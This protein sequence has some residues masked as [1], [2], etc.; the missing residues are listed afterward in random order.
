MKTIKTLLMVTSVLSAVS[1][2]AYAKQ[3]QKETLTLDAESIESLSVEAGA[4]E[5]IIRGDKSTTEISVVATVVGDEV[6]PGDYILSL[7]ASGTIAKLVAKVLKNS[8]NYKNAAYIDVE[9]LMPEKIAL[10]VEDGSGDAIVRDIAND[11]DVRDGSG[12]LEIHTIAGELTVDDGSGSILITTISGD[13]EVEDG[14]GALEILTISGDL[15][16]DD[17]SGNLNVETVTGNVEIED[18][19]GRIRVEN[20]TGTVTIDDGS[21]DI[22]V[23]HVADFKLLDDGSGSIKMDNVGAK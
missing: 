21:G 2:F 1:L 6:D 4:G 11:V 12:D 7:E 5:L 3:L 20:V 23:S 13:T 8:Y 19:S 15:S 14:S 9:V 18:G 10:K 17:G 22:R 16:I